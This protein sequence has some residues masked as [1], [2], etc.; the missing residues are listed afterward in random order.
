MRLMRG[1]RWRDDE[2]REEPRQKRVGPAKGRFLANI[3]ANRLYNVEHEE[4]QQEIRI[5]TELNRLF[6]PKMIYGL[7]RESQLNLGKAKGHLLEILRLHS[8]LQVQGLPVNSKPEPSR[9]ASQAPFFCSKF[10]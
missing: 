2:E 6:D 5:S 10:L 3:R 1:G 4:A 8:S 7:T 9:P